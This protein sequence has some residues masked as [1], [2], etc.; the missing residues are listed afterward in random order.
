MITTTGFAIVQ[1]GF[2][3]YGVGQTESAAWEDAA[4][5]LDDDTLGEDTTDQPR[6]HGEIYC[7]PATAALIEAV[8]TL[9]G[10]VSFEVEWPN[11][12]LADEVVA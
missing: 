7:L 1:Y 6:V 5:W 11:V 10:D 4:E 12:L 3:I 9:G 2:A 8:N